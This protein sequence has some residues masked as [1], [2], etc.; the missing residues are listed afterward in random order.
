MELSGLLGI[1]AHVKLNFRNSTVTELSLLPSTYEQKQV[2]GFLKHEGTSR[3]EIDAEPWGPTFSVSKNSS[4]D[5]NA[6]T[7]RDS[8]T[9]ARRY[10]YK[11]QRDKE[12]KWT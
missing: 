12:R 10:K 5:G 9:F 4:R 3:H 1:S 11:P 2:Y 7:R 8:G 6:M